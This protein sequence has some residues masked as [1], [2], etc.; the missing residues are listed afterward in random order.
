M[1]SYIVEL[2]FE[3][4]QFDFRVCVFN[5]YIILVIYFKEVF[6]Y[7]YIEIFNNYVY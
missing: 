6:V 5:Y 1:Y 7:I 4:L 3:F 2:E